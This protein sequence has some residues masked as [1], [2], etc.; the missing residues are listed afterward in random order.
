MFKAD[1]G[2][3]ADPW[4]AQELGT[5][6]PR[7][8]KS[9]YNLSPHNSTTVSL[10]Y[11]GTG[12]RT[13]TR[14]RAHTHTPKSLDV[15]VPF[16]KWQNNAHSWFST[17]L[18]PKCRLKI[19]LSFITGWICRCK[20]QGYGGTTVYFL[21][22]STCKWACAVQTRVGVV[23]GSTVYAAIISPLWAPHREVARQSSRRASH[24]DWEEPITAWAWPW[25]A[26]SQ[27]FTCRA[28]KPSWIFKTFLILITGMIEAIWLTDSTELEPIIGQIKKSAVLQSPISF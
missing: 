12:S 6:R 18:V 9:T 20:I 19:L 22:K 25:A 10:L 15:A 26:S 17:S 7:P 11:W 13:H 27:S 28:A 16:T 8:F 21:K 4:T 23:Q 1:M 24:W 14:T 5:L 3:T 2:S